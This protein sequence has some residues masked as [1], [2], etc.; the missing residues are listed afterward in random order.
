MQTT[1]WGKPGWR[2]KHSVA[3]EYPDNPSID[4]KKL[5][6]CFICHMA[7]VLPCIYCRLSYRQFIGELNIDDGLKD[8]HS[9][10]HLIYSVHNKVNDK[11]RTQGYLNNI[12]PSFDQIEKKY[13]RPKVYEDCGWDFLY[14][15]AYNYPINPSECDKYNY[16]IFFTKLK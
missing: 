5:Y 16:K 1:K 10:N 8:K 13:N 14:A 15:I 3:S 2:L 6:K 9:I 12:N 4:D 11:L 7:N